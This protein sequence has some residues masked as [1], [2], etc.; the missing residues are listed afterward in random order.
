MTGVNLEAVAYALPDRVLTNDELAASY[1]EWGFE[2]LEGRTGV[3]ARHIVE[4]NETA[5]DLAFKACEAL[6]AN[7]DLVPGDM[8]AL[9]FCTETPDHVIPHNSALLHGRLDLPTSVLSFDINL[10]CSGFPYGLEIARSLIA[11]GTANKVLFVTADTYSRLI[12]PGDRA[13][14]VLFGDGAAVTVLGKC[15]PG[16]GIIDV[17]LATAGKQYRRFMV[18]AGGSRTPR[19]ESTSISES[20]RSGNIRSPEDI[21]MDGLGVLSYFNSVIPPSVTDLL[22]RNNLEIS[23]IDAFVFHQASA[24]AL[25]SL[26]KALKIPDEKFIREMIDTGNLVSASIPV[27]LKLAMGKGRIKRGDLVVFC[28]FGV[29]L[30]WGSALVKL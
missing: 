27:T 10:G 4:G 23:D 5:L 7:E 15:A 13:T 14:R 11:G 9:V 18:P 29:G 16:H 30:S 6:F 28:G 19:S 22:Q 26:Q 2:R 25:D 21:K 17:T 3:R 24:A 1:P 8:D 20:D 12:N